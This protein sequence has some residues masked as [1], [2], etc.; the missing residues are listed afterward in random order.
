MR[1]LLLIL[2]SVAVLLPLAVAQC[3]GNAHTG[4]YY[5]D[6]SCGTNGN[7]STV[8]CGI[9]GPFNSITNMQ[10]KSGGYAAGN[11]IC[12]QRGQ[13]YRET[14]TMPSSGS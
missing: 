10:A 7:G 4:T 9:N 6:N 14:F 3:D 1:R 13:T 2:L 12:L 11:Y 8:A 5:V